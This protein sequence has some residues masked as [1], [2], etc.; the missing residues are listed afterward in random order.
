MAARLEPI[1]EDW[2]RALGIVAH[3]DDMEYGTASAVARWTAHGKDVRY[4]LVTRGEAGIA[5]MPPDVVGPI[6][7]Q[8]QRRSCAAVGVSVVEFLDHRDGLVEAGIALR[9]DLA[10]GIRRN[11]PE[12]ILSINH[13]D[14]WGP[15]SWN[16]PDHRAVGRAVLDAVRDAANPWL[17]P[18]CG[19]AWPGVRF[20]AF[21]GSPEVSHAVDVTGYLDRGIESLRCHELYLSN[22]GGGSD[23]MS[24][25][26]RSGAESAGARLGVLHAVAFEIVNF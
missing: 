20:A 6:R 8:E 11:K 15:H 2:S 10:A 18:E 7:E 4:L 14:G 17:F 23:D 26:L 24:S 16:H 22:L 25:F 13:R 3:P 1:P 9:R 12:V 19:P 5:T 21:N